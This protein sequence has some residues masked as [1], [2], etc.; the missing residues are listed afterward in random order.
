MISY[1]QIHWKIIILSAFFLLYSCATTKKQ[2]LSPHIEQLINEVNQLNCNVKSFKGIAKLKGS[3]FGFNLNQRIA[4][5]A[6]LPNQ[7]RVEVLGPLG[8]IMR[9]A[10]ND[11]KLYYSQRA[12]TKIIE[13][14]VN[15]WN[16]F[17][18]HQKIPILISPEELIAYM[19]GQIPLIKPSFADF[20]KEV[21]YIKGKSKKSQKI[22]FKKNSKI[23]KQVETFDKYGNLSYGI[24]ILNVKKIKDFKIPFRLEIYGKKEQ[25]FILNYQN[26]YINTPVDESKFLL[27]RL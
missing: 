24:R 10:I 21:L 14:K 16:K 7:I 15:L 20:Q 1:K 17:L 23:V 11:Q 19:A 6:S 2:S 4:I 12:S 25:N 18:F 8:S 3:G 9:I 13:K 5:I 26:Y 27:N 22:Y